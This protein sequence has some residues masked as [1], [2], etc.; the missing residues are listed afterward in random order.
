[1]TITDHDSIDAAEYL[2]HHADFFLS[3]EV[4]AVMPSGTEMH[5][6][7]YGISERNHAEIQRRRSD[8][9]SLLAYL[10]E[11]KLFFS[12][13]HIFSGLTG[14]RVREDFSFFAARLPAFEIR[15]GQMRS[16]ANLRAE[17]AMQ[18]L[19]KTGTA[20]S[21]SHTMAGLGRTYSEVPNA[22]TI[23]EFLRG[24]RAGGS[25]IHGAHGSY[26]KITMDVYR[27]AWSVLSENPWV[28]PA[29]PLAMVIPIFTAFHWLNEMQFYHTWAGALEIDEKHPAT[30]RT[31][32]SRL[33]AASELS[34]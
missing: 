3:E 32:D 11:Q 6:G 12:A 18:K 9:V 22:A 25:Q 34:V 10:Q 7:V 24:L 21:D 4:T 1:M 20:G 2:R 31:L 14:R 23:D 27:I 29:F 15:N 19:S 13:N 26:L 5:L 33:D 30:V 16:G 17:R 28:L 8:L